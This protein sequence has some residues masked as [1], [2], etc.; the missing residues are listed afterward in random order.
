MGDAPIY[1]IV[2]HE[3]GHAAQAR[4]WFDGEGGAT[5]NPFDSVAYE[6]QADCLGGATL[7]KAARDGY[8]SV[9]PGDLDEIA[10]FIWGLVKDGD[11]GTPADRLAAFQLGY[12]TGDVESRLYNR[13][14]P[15]PGL[16]RAH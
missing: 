4:F 6:Q 13:G 11:H 5:P 9:D 16:K 3:V 12:G 1:A 8:L 15:P 10:G 7:S 14:V 2:A